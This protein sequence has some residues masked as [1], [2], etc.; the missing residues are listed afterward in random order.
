MIRSGV[1]KSDGTIVEPETLA[2][3]VLERGP[4]AMTR[5]CGGL[6]KSN[7]P[8]RLLAYPANRIFDINETIDTYAKRWVTSLDPI[9]HR[10]VLLSYHIS[11]EAFDALLRDDHKEFINVRTRDLIALERSFMA[12]NEVSAY[13]SDQPEVSAIDV[14]DA[15]PLSE[16]IANTDLPT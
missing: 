8:S 14:E 3:E 9:A 12:T 1:R 15:V 7:A 5:V 2:K 13:A 4:E 11:P 16:A 10:D 6:P